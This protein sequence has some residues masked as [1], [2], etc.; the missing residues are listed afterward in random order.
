MATQ[1]LCTLA[2]VRLQLEYRT[3]NTD[4]DA[5]ITELIT[6]ASDVIMREYEREFAPAVASAT[7]TIPVYPGSRDRYGNPIVDLAPYDLRTVTTAQMHPESSSPT[8]LTSGTDYKLLPA[9]PRDSVYT[10]VMVASDV[11]LRSDHL[12]D[13]G[14]AQ[15]SIAGAWGF[16]TVPNEVNQACVETVKAWLERLPPSGFDIDQGR[17]ITPEMLRSFS[18]PTWARMKL[19]KFA[20]HSQVF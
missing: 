5:L 17:Q 13:F 16:A 8:T 9:V 14:Y 7:R 3:A 15:I 11:S 2:E 19:Q 12:T 20:R 4:R 1:D 18:I 10:G 6:Q